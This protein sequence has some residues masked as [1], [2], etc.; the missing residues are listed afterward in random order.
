MLRL[1]FLGRR[2]VFVY[3]LL[4]QR[5]KE[6]LGVKH[7]AVCM[8]RGQKKIEKIKK[9]CKKVLT[10]GFAD[11]ILTLRLTNFVKRENNNN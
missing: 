8:Q 4:I 6:V 7:P 2:G 10:Y 3:L 5:V 1:W 11:S 9:I